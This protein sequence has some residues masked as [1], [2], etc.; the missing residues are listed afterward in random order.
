MKI[1]TINGKEY[2]AKEFDFNT[3]CDLEDLGIDITSGK[4]KGMAF[5]RAYFS[6]SSGLPLS[7]A[8]KE[9]EKHIASG[10]NLE[11]LSEAIGNAVDESEFFRNLG[12][13]AKEEVAE[14]PSKTEKKEN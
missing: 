10:G 11:K 12:T 1:F 14:S 2:R 9:I 13:D 8:G 6:L 4:M 3:I 7:V 5:L